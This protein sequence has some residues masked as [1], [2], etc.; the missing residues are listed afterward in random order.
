MPDRYSS[1]IQLVQQWQENAHPFDQV[2]SF[3]FREILPD[4]NPDRLRYHVEMHRML[5]LIKADL[6]LLKASRSPSNRDK[7]EQ[8]VKERSVKLIELCQALLR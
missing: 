6:A 2:E 1:F 3:F 8:Q 4:Q 7:Y 5:K